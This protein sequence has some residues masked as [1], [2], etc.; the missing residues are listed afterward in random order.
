GPCV[1]DPPAA[2]DVD[3]DAVAA[4]QIGVEG[5][6]F[7]VLND[8]RPAFLKPWVRAGAGGEKPRLDPFAAPADVALVQFGPDVILGHA[9]FRH[10]F[11]C[12]RFHPGNG[13][14]AGVVGA[15]HGQNLVRALDGAGAFRDDLAL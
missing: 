3:T 15:A 10:V 4:D 5:D 9:A 11:P 1:A 12:E 6:D 8:S 2:A 7:I 13:G 14:F